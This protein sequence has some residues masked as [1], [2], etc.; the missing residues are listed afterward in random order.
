MCVNIFLIV[1]TILAL[2]VV[3]LIV[4]NF[5]RKIRFILFQLCQFGLKA[6]K[7]CFT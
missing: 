4:I 2:W 7:F 1:F 6:G 5:A 3:V